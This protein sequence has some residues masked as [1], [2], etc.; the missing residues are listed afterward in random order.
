[1]TIRYNALLTPYNTF[2]LPARAVR[3]VEIESEQE[4]VQ[5]IQKNKEPLRVLGGGSN[6]LLSKD[7]EE[8]LLL[9]Q[10]KGRSI[11]REDASSLVSFGGGENWHEAVLFA[12]ENNLGGIENLS[13][14]PGTVGASP[15]QNI[16]AYGVELKD[17][18]EELRAVDLQ[19]GESF[20]FRA[21]D[22]RFGYRD[23]IF[24]QELRGKMMITGVTLRLHH[25]L[26]RVRTDYGAIRKT[27]SERGIDHPSIHEVSRAVIDI[28]RSKLPDPKVLGNSGSFFKNPVLTPEQFGK[29][30]SR[31][32]EPVHYAL[33]DGHFKV[34]A[35]WLIEQAGWRGK[36]Q[37]NVGTYEHQ[38]LVLVNHGEATG[39]EVWAQAQA[40]QQDV[41]NKFGI[42]LEPEVNVW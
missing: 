32:A 12:L 9:N 24:K 36:R 26:H 33:P 27:L 8:T 42:A 29:L 13:L 31:I 19:S 21:E 38:A 1:M 39:P 7:V 6:L 4:L 10:I 14:I 3:L 22:M 16:G 11:I 34:P 17:V 15:I 25:D 2:G 18:F 41:L 5:F 20:L 23:S 28:R 35:G 37:G 30:Q 40:I